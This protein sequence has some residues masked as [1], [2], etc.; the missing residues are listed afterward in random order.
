MSNSFYIIST[1]VLDTKEE[2]D[3]HSLLEYSAVFD[4]CRYDCFTENEF[5]CFD[6]FP[7]FYLLYSSEHI[8]ISFLS[9]YI[10]NTEIKQQNNESISSNIFVYGITHPKYRNQS[11]F[12]KLFHTA[13][14]HLGQSCFH[15]ENIYFPLNRQMNQDV[16]N[17]YISS[18]YIS[19]EYSEF[20]MKKDL[21]TLG[22]ISQNSAESFIPELEYEENEYGNEFSL[23]ISDK[24]I[25]GCLIEYLSETEAMIYQFG[26]IDEEQG[27]GYGKTGLL[28]ICKSLKEQDFSLVSLQVTGKNKKAHRLYIDCGFEISEEIQYFIKNNFDKFSNC[29]SSP[30]SISLDNN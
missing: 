30:A 3:I 29:D 4:G 26:I 15:L 21:T 23:W 1:A 28:L 27:K 25:G 22:V 8:L 2:L 16:I 24:Y 10:E 5:N 17:H 7:C 13:F 6:N 14:K 20:L 19:Y 9:V 11:Y 12:S 18:D